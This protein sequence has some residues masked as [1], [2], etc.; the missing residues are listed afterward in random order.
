MLPTR[1]MKD[2]E[3][4]EDFRVSVL[5]R[6][7]AS[8]A[9]A[10]PVNR[11][12]LVTD[13][14]WF[15][16]AGH[17]VIRRPHGAEESIVILCTEGVG[18]VE[19][20]GARYGVGPSTVALIPQHVPHAYGSSTHSPWTIWWCHLR[21]ADVLDLFS[22]TGT[23]REKP[24]LGL[25]NPERCVALID[26]ILTGMTRDQSPV[27]LVAA[28][29]AAFKLLTQIA[30]DRLTADR[31]DPLQ[32]AMDYL[33]ERLD[34]SIRV[35]DL[36]RLVGVSKSRLGALFREST[37]GG[38][39]AHHTALR[40]ARARQLLDTGRRPVGEIASAVGYDDALYFSRV[41]HRVHGISPTEYRAHR[42]G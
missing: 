32:R 9:L 31:D 27:R 33:A 15:H 25:W 16:Q 1:P 20:D 7:A 13:V 2:F 11:K 8:E 35:G 21:G 14:G 23:T 34:S 41:F 5:P 18:W 38:I 39:V 30:S 37:G 29:G 10:R 4:I 17:H 19:V 26:E 3:D 28:A 24:L 36:A 40:M 12:L 22:A 6:P 42:K